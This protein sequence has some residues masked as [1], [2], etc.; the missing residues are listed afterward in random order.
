[1][2][3]LSD[4]QSGQTV[5]WYDVRF[6]GRVTGTV[7]YVSASTGWVTVKLNGPYPVRSRPDGSS[8][9]TTEHI[10]HTTIRAARLTPRD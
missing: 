1:M 6:G 9:L 4:V 7:E 2:N 3:E 8:T 5:E 10:T